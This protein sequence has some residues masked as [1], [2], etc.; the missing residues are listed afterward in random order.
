MNQISNRLI[1]I[2][3][4]LLSGDS[5]TSPSILAQSLDVSIRTIYRELHDVE[6]L[7]KPFNLKLKSKSKL[8]YKLVGK[9]ENKEKFSEYLKL[10]TNSYAWKSVEER[11][12]LI[13]IEIL[14]SNGYMKLQT[15]ADKL[16]VSESTISR[17][18]EQIKPSIANYDID[19]FTK[20][21]IGIE[22]IGD[23]ENIRKAIS[24]LVY[25]NLEMTLALGLDIKTNILNYF[26]NQNSGILGLLNKD[27]LEEV[28]DVLVSSSNNIIYRITEFSLIGLVI[29]LTVAINRIRNGE[30][31]VLDKKL[32]KD[33]KQE[34][35]YID[36][37][38][39]A[40]D[41]EDRFNIKFPE[42]ELGYILMHLKGTRPRNISNK[43]GQ[44][45]DIGN[46][47][48]M[49]LVD[50]LIDRFS[51]ITDYNFHNDEMLVIG[52]LAH[53][54][55]SII[56][57]SNNLEIRNPLI[58][59]IKGEYLELFTIVKETSQIISEELEVNVS[60][61][62]IAY[63]T[64]HFGAAIERMK[65]DGESQSLNIGVVCA[66]GIGISALL[67]STIK[68][69]FPDISLVEP[70]S[71]DQVLNEDLKSMGFDLLVATLNIES[72][73]PTVYV[74]PLLTDVDLSMLRKAMDEIKISNTPKTKV[75]LSINPDIIN[76]IKLI[77]V[78][79][80]QARDDV[81]Y[82]IILEI[83]DNEKL[84]Q[85]IFDKVIKR[86]T[87]APVIIKDKKFVLYHCSIET[88]DKAYVVLFYA[89]SDKRSL[90][91]KDIDIG[92][93]MLLPKPPVAS[94]RYTLSNISKA[95][96]ENDDLAISIQSKSLKNIKEILFESMRENN[97]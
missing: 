65:L 83:T 36:A 27:D 1:N 14:K 78:D 75:K 37:R 91:Y 8:G 68:S 94:D 41:I 93:M 82:K 17:D 3:E 51:E 74:N 70:L 44:D 40:G 49:I 80:N 19:V 76:Q 45:L 23:E 13:L 55:P 72:V 9:K 24:D 64:L 58:N 6:E 7:L 66:S 59:E 2:F 11:R 86:E 32:F 85:E 33:I 81:I 96:V 63:L 25:S 26:K 87:M 43:D 42:D 67:S 71:V 62:E 46:Y 88:I 69:N 5:F 10:N 56:R 15:L 38:I 79:L 53:L 20:K 47:E 12:S 57:L 35:M 28:V 90:L 39:I 84:K 22:V 48:A 52:L 21:G 18:I 54:A 92:A 30:Q 89:D 50:K 61:D 97:E 34:K 31:I 77:G 60:D 95:L 29:H 4:V 16:N 73:I